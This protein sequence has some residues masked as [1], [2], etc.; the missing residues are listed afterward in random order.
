M[1]KK[2]DA[3][4]KSNY[5]PVSCLVSASKALEKVVCNQVTEFLEKINY[6]L[7]TSMDSELPVPGPA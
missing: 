6:F 3:T 7:I 4:D 1:I 2:G 5:R